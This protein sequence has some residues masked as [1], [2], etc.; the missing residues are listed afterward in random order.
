MDYVT[1]LL[2]VRLRV[3]LTGR[4]NVKGTAVKGMVLEGRAYSNDRTD[5]AG[6]AVKG[7]TQEGRTCRI[8]KAGTGSAIKGMVCK[9][10]L[11][12]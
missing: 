8:D 1:S 2:Q 3:C 11:I 12:V 7:T 5:I 10:E 4:A 9:G 6:N